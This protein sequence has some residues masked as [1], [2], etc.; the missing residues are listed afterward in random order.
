MCLWN[1]VLA[2]YMCKKN[3]VW[4]VVLIIHITSVKGAHLCL[5]QQPGGVITLWVRAHTYTVLNLYLKET[6]TAYRVLFIIIWS[7]WFALMIAGLGFAPL[8]VG[9]VGWQKGEAQS[10][11]H[12][13]TRS[14][15]PPTPSTVSLFLP[16]FQILLV[17]LSCMLTR[18]HTNTAA[19]IASVMI[20]KSFQS[21]TWISNDLWL[22]ARICASNRV[23]TVAAHFL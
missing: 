9:D 4:Q 8:S 6:K 1:P 14:F 3:S 7:C 15:I 2:V 21:G 10:E 18:T 5:Q 20:R 17:S 16:S 22:S 23:F 12:Q 19:H 11:E 13:K